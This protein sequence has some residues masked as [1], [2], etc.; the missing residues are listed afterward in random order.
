MD[1]Y[2]YFGTKRDAT[3][4][5]IK[6]AYNEKI[7]ELYDARNNGAISEKESDELLLEIQRAFEVLSDEDSREAYDEWLAEQEKNLDNDVDIE[8]AEAKKKARAKK[9]KTGK[10][11]I[12]VCLA[13]AVVISTLGWSI[14]QLIKNSKKGKDSTSLPT[15]SVGP[16]PGSESTGAT[17]ST[18][19]SSLVEDVV[20]NLPKVENYGDISDAKLVEE[21]ATSLLGQLNNAGLYNMA[22]NAPYT[23]DEIKEVIL[24]M[25]GAYV[26]ENEVD[27]LSKVD[28][29]LNLAIAPLNS[30]TFIY[31]V[32]YQ[33]GED[34]FKDKVAE[35]AK[36][37]EKVSYVKS[38]LFG[39]ST[40]A[41]YLQWIEDQYYKMVMT[42]DRKEC[43]KIYD[44]V[45]Q[46]LAEYSFGDGFE[47]NGV[48]YK[49]N[50]GVG[51]DKINNGNMLQFLVCIIEPFRTNM[52]SDCYTIT[53][54][55][56]SANPD[57][58]KVDISYE[59]IAEWYT[60][61]CSADDYEFGDQGFIKIEDYSNFAS[62]NQINTTNALL[63]NLYGKNMQ[64][65]S[66]KSLTR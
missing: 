43:A 44:S 5:E 19:T 4:E 66:T 16:N 36:K 42:T 1:F 26:P 49:E 7:A 64:N 6:E 23:V 2:T 28:E 27:A 34:S 51:L 65:N 46:S 20:S 21:R 53:D 55:Y 3:Y 17:S 13:A 25:N 31:S 59:Q 33:S 61:L 29:F 24:Y 32:G 56:L 8:E 22:T 41:P 15:I 35:N 37:L 9:N 57:E 45:M 30:E 63:E 48:V 14:S 40:I 62:V 60:P 39:D 10:G 50:M 38:L 52:T 12:A 18:E 54:K 47:L 58:N 11:I